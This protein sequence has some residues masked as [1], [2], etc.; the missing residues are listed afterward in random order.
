M[1]G[2]GVIDLK[3]ADELKKLSK[4]I[5]NNATNVALEDGLI[6]DDEKELLKKL[7]KTFALR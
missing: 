4:V 1:H 5:L 2:S 6:E 7:V 3:E